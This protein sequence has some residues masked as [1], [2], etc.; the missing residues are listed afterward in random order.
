MEVRLDER[1]NRIVEAVL[2]SVRD[3][4]FEPQRFLSEGLPA[5]MGWNFQTLDEVMRRCVGC[6][7][8]ALPRRTI[9][10]DNEPEII[11]PTEWN[12]YEGAAA[13][14]LGLPTLIVVERG[15]VDTGIAYMGGGL[16]I[17]FKPQD[18]D[19]NWLKESTF[20]HRFT[21]WLDQLRARRD[22]FLGYCSKA[23]PTANAINL[24]LKNCG[25]TV[26]DWTEFSGG[27]NILDEIEKASASCSAGIF[28]FTND[29]YLKDDATEKLLVDRAA[30]RDNVVFEAGYF[31]QAK[32]RERVLIIR[33]EGVKMPA[34]V[35]GTIYLPLK[36]PDDIKPIE[37]QLRS[38][39][40]RRL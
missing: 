39:V 2:A 30:P 21:L 35:G 32:G 16:P 9:R 10:I 6:I 36:D 38:F 22:I 13:I 15:I 11:L 27:G 3:A 31:T 26:F 29:D 14:T 40:E 5:S 8:L 18:A 37:T 25:A 23:R 12:H 20:K 17:L 4:G 19:E 7:V 34:D 28:L 33:Q 1:R 24:F